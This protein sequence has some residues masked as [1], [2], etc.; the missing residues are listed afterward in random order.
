MNRLLLLLPALLSTP[1]FAQAP[2]PAPAAAQVGATARVAAPG[3]AASPSRDPVMTS[4]GVAAGGSV[5]WI[6]EERFRLVHA[7][8]FDITQGRIQC[9][10]KPLTD[11]MPSK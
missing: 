6:Y 9:W 11:S 5:T 1:A 2:A 3:Q 4:G 10:N 7:C 8:V